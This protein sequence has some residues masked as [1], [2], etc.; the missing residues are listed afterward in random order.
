[1]NRMTLLAAVVAGLT[2]SSLT[3]AAPVRSRVEMPNCKKVAKNV[4]KVCK[5]YKAH[6]HALKALRK[7]LKADHLTP[8]YATAHIKAVK[9]V[10]KAIRAE[11][12]KKDVR[13]KLKAVKSTSKAVLK[14]LNPLAKDWDNYR[15]IQ[16][17]MKATKKKFEAA[18][19]E[20]L[21]APAGINCKKVSS[22]TAPVCKTFK[23][24]R[25]ALN[26]LRKQLKDDELTPKYVRAH[27]KALNALY[28]AVAANKSA[29]VVK[30]KKAALEETSHAVIEQ[31]GPLAEEWDNYQELAIKMME[32]KHQFEAALK[33]WLKSAEDDEDDFDDGE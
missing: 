3:V 4:T 14:Q 7:Q 5:S 12:S 30:D 1:M 15:A 25:K 16:K 29:D 33:K 24:H 11:K 2:F 28:S 27:I 31:L 23:A 26:A 21:G 32:T 18:Y 8:K 20:W 9:E 19:K 13:T 6:L 10:F 22:K 17:D